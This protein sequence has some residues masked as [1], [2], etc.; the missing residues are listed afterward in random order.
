LVSE[1]KEHLYRLRYAVL[2]A[3]AWGVTV[4][5]DVTLCISVLKFRS[6]RLYLVGQERTGIRKDESDLGILKL[7]YAFIYLKL[8]S[9]Q[10]YCI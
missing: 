7:E 4:F 3:V 6:S 9:F 10:K 5:S 2:T 1:I 8:C